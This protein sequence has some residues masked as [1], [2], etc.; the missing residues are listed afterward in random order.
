MSKVWILTLLISWGG[1]PRPVVQTYNFSTKEE[2]IAAQSWYTTSLK[3]T[4]DKST[5]YPS[6]IK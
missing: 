6:Y 1:S 4:V 3:G 5:C 2:C